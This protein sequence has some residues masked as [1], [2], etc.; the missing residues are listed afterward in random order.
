[1]LTATADV[2]SRPTPSKITRPAAIS[3]VTLPCTV[4]RAR[5]TRWIT[6]RIGQLQNFLQQIG[7]TPT[8][9]VQF[10]AHYVS[11][12]NAI[13]AMI[14]GWFF[15]RFPGRNNAVLLLLRVHICE[16]QPRMRLARDWKHFSCPHLGI[17]IDR[18]TRWD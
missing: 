1:M 2:S 9:F 16:L 7:K 12:P 5:F 4:T 13:K 18:N 14:G 6:A 17:T 3:P 8:G 15:D 11:C 10:I